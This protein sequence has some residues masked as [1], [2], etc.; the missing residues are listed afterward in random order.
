MIT[1]EQRNHI[2]NN[3]RVQVLSCTYATNIASMNQIVETVED[4]PYNF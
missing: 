3:C 1:T 4:P 2:S